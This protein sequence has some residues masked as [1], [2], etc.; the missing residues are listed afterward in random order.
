MKKFLPCI[1][2]LF[3]ACSEP[4]KE[5]TTGYTATD[6]TNYQYDLNKEFLD[7]GIEVNIDISGDSSEVLELEN[8]MFDA[9][10]DRR[11]QTSGKF[12]KWY[13]MGFEKVIVTT[14]SLKFREEH[15]LSHEVVPQ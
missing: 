1:L 14:G 12:D 13:K 2:L 8:Q 7:E 3:F 9:V 5:T 6:R 10:W 11:L 4:V 15:I